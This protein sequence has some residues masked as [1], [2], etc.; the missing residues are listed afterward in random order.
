MPASHQCV[1]FAVTKCTVIKHS[2][3]AAVPASSLATL[4]SGLPGR[5]GQTGSFPRPQ[6]HHRPPVPLTAQPAHCQKVLII[7]NY[8]PVCTSSRSPTGCCN[9]LHS[10]I[11]G[12]GVR[13]GETNPSHTKFRSFAH[14]QNP[15]VRPILA[16]FASR[17]LMP[18]ST[19]SK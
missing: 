18:W 10:R 15:A 1:A 19:H 9:F 17:C 16:P 8:E 3:P 11:P 13:S 14:R 7:A 5:N 4:T 2:C 12:C 6:S